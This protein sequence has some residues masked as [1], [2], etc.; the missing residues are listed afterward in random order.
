MVK[1]RFIILYEDLMVDVGGF[2]RFGRPYGIFEKKW[3]G[4][5]T[6]INT[7][8]TM[9]RDTKR[10]KALNKPRHANHTEPIDDDLFLM[11]AIRERQ[12]TDW[13]KLILLN[14]LEFFVATSGLSN[15]SATQKDRGSLNDQIPNSPH[16]QN[17]GEINKLREKRGEGDFESKSSWETS[18]SLRRDSIHHI[19]PIMGF[20]EL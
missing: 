20:L 3:L 11:F 6:H 16:A 5:F 2:A 9:L 10:S 13:P 7:Y 8:R 19:H 12:R 15:A 14:M 1:D 17:E 18:R 4:Q